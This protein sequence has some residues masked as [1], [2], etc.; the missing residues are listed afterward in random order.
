MDLKTAAPRKHFFRVEKPCHMAACHSFYGECVHALPKTTRCPEGT[1]LPSEP[2]SGGPSSDQLHLY[3]MKGRGMKRGRSPESDG[4]N[5]SEEGG[6][7]IADV[8]EDA[9]MEAMEAREAAYHAD[10]VNV[11]R[12]PEIHRAMGLSGPPNRIVHSTLEERMQ[13]MRL[14]PRI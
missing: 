11:L 14:V 8:G 1:G 9:P 12:Q 7:Q 13:T 3:Q 5:T 4:D 10:L 6:A 2:F